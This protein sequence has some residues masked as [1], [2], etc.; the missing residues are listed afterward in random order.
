MFYLEKN[1]KTKLAINPGSYQI[2]KGLQAIRL[3][4]PMTDILLVNKE[5]AAK[6][7]NK[8][9]SA[10]SMCKSFIKKGVGTVVITDSL[11]GSI[12]M[13]KDETYFMP[14][15]PIKAV[16]KTGAGDAYTSGFLSAT[17]LGYDLPTAMQWGTANAGGVIQKIGA[18]KG[19]LGKT[20]I[21]KI[22]KKYSKIKPIKV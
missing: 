17:L 16:A 20:E 6:I 11:K 10:L 2:K 4:L 7:L 18:Q 14:I 15:F 3:I 8:K 19:L 12:T 22:I 5:E 1:P 9:A 21:N 13:N